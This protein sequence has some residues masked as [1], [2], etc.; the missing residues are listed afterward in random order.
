MDARDVLG[1]VH[2]TLAKIRH[3]ART[4]DLRREHDDVDEP[5]LPVIGVVRRRQLD[6]VDAGEQ[7]RISSRRFGAQRQRPVELLQ[8]GDSDRSLHVGP[9]VVEPELTWLNQPPPS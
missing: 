4:I 8:L 1:H 6:A 7:L 5:G 3:H 9:A 2:S